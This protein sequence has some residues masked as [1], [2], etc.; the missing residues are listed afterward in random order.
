MHF[1]EWK[2]YMWNEKHPIS[3]KFIPKGLIDSTGKSILVQ[4]M[5]CYHYVQQAFTERIMA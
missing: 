2:S 4:I 3:Q 5:A 1:V